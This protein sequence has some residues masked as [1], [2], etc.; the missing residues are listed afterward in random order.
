MIGLSDLT[1]C[2][3]RCPFCPDVKPPGVEFANAA[4]RHKLIGMLT[5]PRAIVLAALLVSIA[6]LIH[7]AFPRYQV[8]T[9]RADAGVFTRVDR[10]RGTLE[11]GAARQDARPRWI[12]VNTAQAAQH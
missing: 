3:A 9:L 2:G 5:T 8:E 10:W 12:T 11:V 6:A 1:S 4:N 7:A